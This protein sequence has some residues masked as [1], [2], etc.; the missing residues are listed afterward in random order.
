LFSVQSVVTNE[1]TGVVRR[2]I[3]RDEQPGAI[4]TWPAAVGDK[5]SGGGAPGTADNMSTEEVKGREADN[6]EEEH[7]LMQQCPVHL[8]DYDCIRGSR[9]GMEMMS[10]SLVLNLGVTSKSEGSGTKKARMNTDVGNGQRTRRW[11]SKE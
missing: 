6:E 10:A 3:D 2:R 7:V 4:G 9:W 1:A 5:L 8:G 11:S